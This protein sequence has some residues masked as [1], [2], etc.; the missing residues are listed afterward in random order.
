MKNELAITIKV[1]INTYE[2]FIWYLY[3]IVLL[4]NRPNIIMKYDK[5]VTK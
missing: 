5:G 4:N 3:K 1:N 2:D